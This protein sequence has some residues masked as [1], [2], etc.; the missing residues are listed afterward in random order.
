MGATFSTKMCFGLIL[1]YS[2]GHKIPEL[3][4]WEQKHFIHFWYLISKDGK[5]YTFVRF[6]YSIYYLL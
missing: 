5:F 4:F 1:A 6:Y 2:S 3:G